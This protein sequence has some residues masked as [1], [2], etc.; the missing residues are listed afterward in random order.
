MAIENLK[1]QHDRVRLTLLVSLVLFLIGLFA[2]VSHWDSAV[3]IIIFACLFRLIGVW[4]VRRPYNAA[5]MEAESIAAAEKAM[6]GVTYVRREEIGAELLPELG[7]TP[8]IQ[9]IPQSQRYHVLRGQI[10]ERNVTVAETAFTPMKE[11]NGSI[12]GKT[13]SGTL[14]VAEDSLPE[15]EQ[16]VILWR[17]PFDGLVPLSEYYNSRKPAEAPRELPEN[18]AACFAES[19]DRK[20]FESAAKTLA[21]YCKGDYGIALS[22]RGGK[23]SLFFPGMFY[24]RKP[25]LSPAPTEELL[26]QGTVPGIELMR[27]LLKTLGK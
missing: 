26:R 17:Q 3:P 14:L 8:E 22:A 1:K 27:D 15:S 21:P 11:K 10:A 18:W 2:L 20:C 25:D 16:W 9:I 23:L 7:L 24:A 12:T 13:V 6:E 4:L 5:W 19:E